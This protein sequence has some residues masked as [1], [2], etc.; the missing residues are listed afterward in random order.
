MRRLWCALLLISL[1]AAPAVADVANK[2]A[3]ALFD[4]G[5][6]LAEKGKFVEAL[7]R[8]RAAYALWANAKILLN[9]GTTLRQLGRNAE[10][11]DTYEKYLAS[12]DADPKR[13]PEVKAAL[14]ETESK[15][16]KLEIT[17]K[18]KKRR[19]I[20]DGKLAGE[21]DATIVVRV[22]PGSHTVLGDHETDNVITRNVAVAAGETRSVELSAAVVAAPPPP[23]PRP[24][25]P[26]EDKPTGSST[27]RIVG[28]SVTGV[29]VVGVL[30]GGFFGLRAMSKR[31][32]SR[33]H[34]RPD[35]PNVCSGEGV[36]LRDE[37][38]AAGNVSTIA[39]TVGVV[40]VAAGI[41]IWLTAPSEPRTSLRL[42]PTLAGA[43]LIGSF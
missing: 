19:V 43:V 9:I 37:A 36:A 23:A 34:C 30:V 13:L 22:E 31:D 1:H 25:A 2:A 41:T 38:I 6:E 14:A 4:E 26:H 20:V 29:G 24:P 15:S 18:G 16:S 11:A 3:R 12:P 5:N 42:S 27:Q 10:A 40:A 33:D 7:D 32:A 21:T 28:M 17:S 35:D 8:F 39:M